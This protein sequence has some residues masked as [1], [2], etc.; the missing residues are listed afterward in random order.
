MVPGHSFVGRS[1]ELAQLEAAFAHARGG[2]ARTVIVGGE[3]GVGK[4]RLVEAFRERAAADGVGVLGGACLELAEAAPPY[5]PFVEALRGLVSG[6]E[7]ARLPALLGPWRVELARV[8]PELELQI[9]PT[10]SVE[11][12]RSGQARL[13]EI[14]LGVLERVARRGPFVLVIEDVQWADRST[15]DLLAF[16]VR[17]LRRV[18]VLVLVT[19]RS[20]ALDRHSPV[21]PFLAELQRDDHVERIQLAAFG[22]TEVGRL[23]AGMTGDVPSA[24][25]V[26]AIHERTNGNAFFAEQLVAA[27]APAAALLPGIAGLPPRLSDVLR[28][29]VASFPDRARE[30][31][32]AAA[33]AGRHTDDALLEAVLDLPSRDVA[34]G[35]REVIDRG[36]LERVRPATIGSG[37]GGV[38]PGA[39]TA[40]AAYAFHHALL[41]EVVYEEL[42]PGE[43]RRLHS[44]FAEAL[45]NRG[46]VGG[47]PVSPAD[48]AYHW[49]AAGDA[50]R[51]VSAVVDAAHASEA[52]YAFTEAAR[53]YARALELWDR[54]PDAASLAGIDRVTLLQQAAE[55]HMLVGDHPRAIALGE[56]A[57]RSAEREGRDALVLGHLHDRLRWFQWDAGDHAAAAASLDEALRLIPAEPPTT[58]RARALAQLAGVRMYAGRFPEAA[59]AATAAIEVARASG[60]RGEEA[61]ALG[62]L[63]WVTA[64]RGEAAEGI[65]LY[66][67]A[68]GIAEELG[69]VEGIAL[70]YAEL[71][72]MLDAIGR[73]EASLEA[74]REGFAV[75]SGLGLE[76]TYGGILLGYAINALLDLGRWAEARTA[77]DTAMEHGYTG[78]PA[79]WLRINEARLETGQG[80][81]EAAAAA[82]R[83]AGEVHAGMQAPGFRPKLL[84]VTAELAVTRGSIDDTRRAWDDA[85]A[86]ARPDALPDPAVAWLGAVALRA[87]ADEVERAIVRRDVSRA[88]DG[89]RAGTRTSPCAWVSWTPRSAISPAGRRGSR[90]CSR[91]RHSAGP[92][93]RASDR[94]MVRR[95]GLAPR[96]PGMSPGVPTRRRTAASVSPRRRSRTGSNEPRPTRAL[97]EAHTTAV[98]LG[99]EPLRREV[100]ELARRGRVDLLAADAGTSAGSR[101]GD[102]GRGFDGTSGRRGARADAA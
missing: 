25:V 9:P 32:R 84:A 93:P 48:L 52:A 23:I 60:G 95:A 13:F 1:E 34:E 67:A 26:D 70:G 39:M 94:R 11:F 72:R 4:T 12:D 47:V 73:P 27:S 5:G 58:I 86:M 10:G 38:A 85:W 63:G 59:A 37:A 100:E 33:A 49:D 43:R 87:E 102:D 68:L 14:I 36:I 101:A 21:L 51:A 6:V 97:R 35:L 91:S 64:L 19:V 76:R 16:L 54:V 82:I 55:S 17:N 56:E 31:L 71:A 65:A 30:V 42:L 15:R 74:A 96:T 75:T 29:R 57:L 8:M 66:R 24:A 20:D 89:A 88:Q 7:P 79:L 18:P 90:G 61:L 62:V 22:R 41:R 50:G 44:A 45:A 46:E 99:A 28:A 53:W 3:A 81:L 98:R 2:E 77:L 69:G 40:A 78:R 83:A 92:R 80:N